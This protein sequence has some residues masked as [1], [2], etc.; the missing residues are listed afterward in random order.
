M[1]CAGVAAP[2]FTAHQSAYTHKMP[3]GGRGVVE[4][5]QAIAAGI[6]PDRGRQRGDWVVLRGQ[7]TGGGGEAGCLQGKNRGDTVL[8]IS[9]SAG[10]TAGRD[11]P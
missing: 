1:K 7:Q 10:K 8:G 2:R 11:E 3:E 5:H 9:L 4:R 6:L